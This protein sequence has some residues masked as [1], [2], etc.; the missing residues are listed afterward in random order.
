MLKLLLIIV[1]SLYVLSRIG[2]FL[3]GIGLS[4]S[5]NR[6]YTKT[7]GGN[8]NVNGDASKKKDKNIKGGEYIDF[9]EVK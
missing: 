3:F 9:E 8:V 7:S 2:R 1:I 6:S 4:S 5:Q